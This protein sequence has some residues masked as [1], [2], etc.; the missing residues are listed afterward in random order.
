MGAKAPSFDKFLDDMGLPRGSLARAAAEKAGKGP[1]VGEEGDALRQVF[2]ERGK[3]VLGGL[4]GEEGQGTGVGVRL[5]R[6]A[7]G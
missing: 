1:W 5:P 7:V 3:E 6:V 4:G 2:A